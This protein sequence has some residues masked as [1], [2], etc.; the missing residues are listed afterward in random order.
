MAPFNPSRPFFRH[1]TA[2]T[3]AYH[4]ATHD[5]QLQLEHNNH[6]P[7][8]YL[9]KSKS[10]HPSISARLPQC[11]LSPGNTIA[12]ICTVFQ[13]NRVAF[14]TRPS[15]PL[16]K[17]PTTYTTPFRYG[18]HHEPERC[19]ARRL[20]GRPCNYLRNVHFPYRFASLSRIQH[21]QW[22][23]SQ[24]LHRIRSFASGSN[25]YSNVSIEITPYQV[26]LGV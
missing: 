6:V 3:Q 13:Q 8:A 11:A 7:I 4:T 14:P 9:S 15:I 2:H 10:V 22:K 5:K 26:L 17:R 24:G 25:D 18:N 12:C 21:W 19:P 20:Q 23:D 1:T 16:N